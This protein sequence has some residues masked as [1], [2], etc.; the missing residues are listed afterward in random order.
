MG[1]GRQGQRRQ[2]RLG[3]LGA[4]NGAGLLAATLGG[5]LFAQSAAPQSAFIGVPLVQ[6]APVLSQPQFDYPREALAHRV[7]G[8]VVV[9]VLVGEDG[10]PERH[11]IVRAEP[12]LIFDAVINAAI[13]EFR[14]ATATQ[15][16]RPAR[17]E[18]QL[19]LSFDPQSGGAK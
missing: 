6:G 8:I 9:A 15:N 10:V 5:G 18:T 11:R 12:P 13:P 1:Q 19:T 4:L 7:A 16:G 3:R 17:Y 14:F 2:G